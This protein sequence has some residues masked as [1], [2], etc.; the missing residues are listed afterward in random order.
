MRS[1][2]VVISLVLAAGSGGAAAADWSVYQN[3][4]FGTSVEIPA[5]AVAGPE[6]ANG[7]GRGFEVPD[8]LSVLVY[9][10]YWT[11]LHDDW[12]DYRGEMAETLRGPGTDLTEETIGDDWFVIAGRG[13]GT[14]FRVRVAR[15]A[16]CG[17]DVAHH[18]R[19]SWPTDRD[20]ELAPVAERITASLGCR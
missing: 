13:N 4:R 6:P 19:V 18:V 7:D 10:G 3:D 11:I 2:G 9:G 5:E 14:A 12:L 20:A 8:G 17:D 16:A 1:I 15:F